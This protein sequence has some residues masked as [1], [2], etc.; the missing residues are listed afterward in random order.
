MNKAKLIMER[1]NK[2]VEI[3]IDSLHFFVKLDYKNIA[4]LADTRKVNAK[5]DKLA[6]DSFRYLDAYGD[7]KPEFSE[8]YTKTEK[9]AAKL[10]VD[11]TLGKGAF[12]KLYAQFPDLD[13]ITSIMDTIN[14]QLS[15]YLKVGV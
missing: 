12:H 5:V 2:G 7:V 14:T 10:I 9:K 13:H 8:E 1:Q 4:K 11:H 15:D 3:S 6:C